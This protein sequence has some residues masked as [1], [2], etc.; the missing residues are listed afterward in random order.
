MIKPLMKV[1]MVAITQGVTTIHSFSILL[2]TTFESVRSTHV[3]TP[4]ALNLRCPSNMTSYLAMLF[5]HL[6]A[7]LVNCNLA[8]SPSR[9]RHWISL[10]GDIV[11]GVVN[12]SSKYKGEET[13]GGMS[14]G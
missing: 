4:M 14:E 3:W 11:M 6:S 7:S 13:H 1:I 8:L 5:V 12:T 2:E 10:L 9:E